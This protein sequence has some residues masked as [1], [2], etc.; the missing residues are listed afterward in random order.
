[1]PLVG[2][3]KVVGPDPF[4]MVSGKM[5]DASVAKAMGQTMERT[6]FAQPTADR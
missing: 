4:K 6:V 2:L 1:M 3:E 5:F